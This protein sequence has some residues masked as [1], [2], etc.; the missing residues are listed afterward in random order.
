LWIERDLFRQH[1]PY[2]PTTHISIPQAHIFIPSAHMDIP[3]AHI[4]IGLQATNDRL[5]RRMG[6]VWNYR[7]LNGTVIGSLLWICG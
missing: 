3:T 2:I 4:R 1:T 7:D 6:S 5:Y